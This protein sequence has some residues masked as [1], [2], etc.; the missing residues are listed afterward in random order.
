MI[1]CK[2]VCINFILI[3]FVSAVDSGWRREDFGTTLGSG[4]DVNKIHILQFNFISSESSEPKFTDA[5]NYNI[6]IL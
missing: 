4:N 3:I 2:T 1:Y 5:Q 6:P